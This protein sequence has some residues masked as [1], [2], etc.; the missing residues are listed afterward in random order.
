M[1][2][3]NIRIQFSDVFRGYRSGTLAENGLIW[4]LILE[5]RSEGA[6]RTFPV[7]T[8]HKCNVHKTFKRCPGHLLNVRTSS[9]RLMYVQFKSCVYWDVK[10]PGRFEFFLRKIPMN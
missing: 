9:E 1:P 10:R 6:F 3:E 5:K 7:E 2:P 8:G 4:F